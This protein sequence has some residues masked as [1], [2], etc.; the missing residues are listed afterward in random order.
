M[1]EPVS[2]RNRYRPDA[3]CRGCAP[4][5]WWAR[6]LGCFCLEA[7]CACCGCCCPGCCLFYRDPRAFSRSTRGFRL[8]ATT[9]GDPSRAALELFDAICDLPESARVDLASATYD[10]AELAANTERLVLTRQVF[11][12]HGT[13]DWG[14]ERPP[15]DIDRRWRA[16][17]EGACDCISL[18]PCPRGWSGGFTLRCQTLADRHPCYAS[19]WAP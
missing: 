12:R 13:L 6:V 3:C 1:R 19:L 9:P 17:V 2:Q 15:A 16:G 5:P 18:S 7:C 10:M 11:L 4:R 14:G 8:V